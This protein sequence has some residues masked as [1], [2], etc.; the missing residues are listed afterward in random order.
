MLR[1]ERHACPKYSLERAR[2][3][4][5]YANNQIIPHKESDDGCSKQF[6]YFTA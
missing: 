4:S 1:S 3:D 2:A 6:H 5:N